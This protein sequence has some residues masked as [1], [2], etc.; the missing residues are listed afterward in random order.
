MRTATAGRRVGHHERVLIGQCR[1]YRRL[2]HI[3]YCTDWN[4]VSARLRSVFSCLPA[5]FVNLGDYCLGVMPDVFYWCSAYRLRRL[6]RRLL[7]QLEHRQS[8]VLQR[9]LHLLYRRL[10][11]AQ[12]T[13]QRILAHERCVALRTT[14]RLLAHGT[15]R[16]PS[17]LRL[18]ALVT[19]A[20]T[21]RWQRR[22]ATLLA[23]PRQQLAR[24][25][26]LHVR[27]H[28][29]ALF[30]RVRAVDARVRPL[31]A[32]DAHV[33]LERAVTEARVA[34]LFALE[35]LVGLVRLHVVAVHLAR[36]RL[37]AALGAR[38]HLVSVVVD[39]IVTL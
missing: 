6:L 28:V 1:V 32:V 22:L 37:E 27:L 33:C 38:H 11:A 12:V 4:V 36:R 13:T 35:R 5:L 39:V 26:S 16:Q 15:D 7:L 21:T 24:V 19:I 20:A 3:V 9:L 34:A 23:R 30:R 29:A 14:E 17:R 25:L 10:V 2:K 18:L 31:V 8:G